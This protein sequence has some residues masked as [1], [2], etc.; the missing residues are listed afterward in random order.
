MRRPPTNTPLQAL[1][2]LNDIQF[3]EAAR[4][5]ADLVLKQPGSDADHVSR[6]FVRLAGREPDTA[7][8]AVLLRTLKEQREQYKSDPKSASK[9]ISEGDTKASP[10]IDPVELAAMTVVVQTA[11]NSDAVIWK[12]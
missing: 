5:L 11:M 3:V 9:L 10:S 6:V 7:E 2:L 1:V 12:R 4:V 8:T